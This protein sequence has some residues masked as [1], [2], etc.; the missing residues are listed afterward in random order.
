MVKLPSVQG[1]VTAALQ[2]SKALPAHNRAK[3]V[4]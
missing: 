3:L 1:K 2:Q 4:C